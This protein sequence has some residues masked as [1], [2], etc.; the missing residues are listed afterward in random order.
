MNS[1]LN[2]RLFRL[3]FEI[4]G[5]ALLLI[6]LSV[7]AAYK[8]VQFRQSATTQEAANAGTVAADLRQAAELLQSGKLDEAEPLLRRVLLGAP[9]NPDA[10]NFL[11]IVLDQHGKASEAEREYRTAIRLNPNGVSAI[12]NLGVLLARTNRSDEAR[13][14]FET[15][16]RMVPN[17]PQATLNLG[18]QY[19]ARGDDLRAIPLLQ[20]AVALGLDG[21]EVRYRL[22]VSLHNLQRLD[23]A[24]QAFEAA[25]TLSPNSAG[26]YYYLGLIAWSRGYEDQAADL[27]D[28]AV[29]LQPDFPE[30]NFMLGE[31]LRKNQRTQASID[32]YKRALAQDA[33]KFVYYARLGGA[34]IVVGQPDQALEIFYRGLQRFPNLPQAHYFVGIAA[35]AQAKYDLAETELRKS[36]ALEP[37]NVNALAQLGFVLIERNQIT[38]AETLLR[39]SL[40]ISD[41]HFYA[42]YDLGRLLVKS[43]R[44]EEALPVLQHA[45]A[46]RSNNPGVHYQLFMALSRLKRKEEADRE[47]ATFKQLDE[48]RKAKP[49]EAE[50]EVE[51]IEDAPALARPSRPLDH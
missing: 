26:S 7:S 44:Y 50:V 29:T 14:A 22:G 34:Y 21:Y 2:L 4:T 35:R 47:L 20:K 49:A 30:A 33:T 42:N 10:H 36:L 6:P 5:L 23:E 18:L 45:A 25:V 39:R 31:A 19:S 37:G 28:R 11:G 48:Q 13:V 38:E 43:R 9:K 17:H 8:T 32:F 40:A 41:R 16:L 46:L 27:W 3:R 51:E 12:A 15:V 1:L 24:K